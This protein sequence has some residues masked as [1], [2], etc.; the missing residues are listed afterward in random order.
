MGK[1]VGKVFNIVLGS[2]L[3]LIDKD[4]GNFV[5]SVG[6]IAV[7]IATGQAWLAGIG[8]SRLS[9]TLAGG[10][11]SVKGAGAGIAINYRQPIVNATRVYGRAYVGGPFC[12]YHAVQ[13]DDEYRYFVV[14][15]AGHEI[16]EIEG[17]YLNDEPVTLGAGNIV[18][19]GVFANNCWIWAQTGTLADT[20]PSVFTSE[21]GGR[22]TA[23]HQGKEI[24]KLY[25]KFNMTDEIISGGMPKICAVVKGARVVD[26]RTGASAYSNNAILCF[27][28]Y[29]RAARS[30]G[31]YGLEDIEVDEAHI[32]AEAN[33]CDED[34]ETLTGTEKRYCIDGVVDT[35]AAAD[36]IRAELL[37][38][39]AGD[40]AEIGPKAY[41]YA[42]A[43]R[44]PV[45]QLH[46][47]DLAENLGY[48]P[49]GTADPYVNEVRGVFISEADLWQPVEFPSQRRDDGMEP[50]TE[51]LEL[52][53][54]KSPAAAQRIARIV[55]NRANADR[56]LNWPMNAKGLD[57]HPMEN[58]TISQTLYPHL[59]N[60]A[61]GIR[62]WA[63]NEAGGVTMMIVEESPDFYDWDVSME[64]A[65][66]RPAINLVKVNPGLIGG[67]GAISGLATADGP[68]AGQIEINFNMPAGTG[69]ASWMIMR[70][71]E[72]ALYED[73]TPLATGSSVPGGAVTHTDTGLVTGDSYSYWVRVYSFFGSTSPLAGPATHE[74]P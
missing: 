21:T 4:V 1:A 45:V 46:E 5:S 58:V 31:G 37:T 12:F 29:M 11:P 74:A 14:A 65:I 49:L 52:K 40:Y 26:Y 32:A 57:R 59:S 9:S 70:A 19:N 71:H 13:G 39:F 17:V 24:A 38:A 6:L 54:T 56:S 27:W 69:A 44:P 64:V 18:T 41:A 33:I 72:S 34:V 8:F 55:L 61:F 3:S 30:D 60:Y 53:F 42:G 28:D 48:R 36:L 63:L 22:W 67:P 51:D 25:V 35:G 7:G 47:G 23:A 62:T 16:H 68:G 20:P 66:D 10:M 15:L 43:W 73:A 50:Q 2:P